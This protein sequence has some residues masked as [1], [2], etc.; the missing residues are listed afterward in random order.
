MSN[1]TSVSNKQYKPKSLEIVFLFTFFSI[2]KDLLT[3]TNRNIY[4]ILQPTIYW[5]E[6][7][8]IVFPSLSH[9]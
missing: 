6:M 3:K 4:L 7:S 9:L 8:D 1:T 2:S 5:T